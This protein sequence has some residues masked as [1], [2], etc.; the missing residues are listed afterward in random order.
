[1]KRVAI[2]LLSLLALASATPPATT[3]VQWRKYDSALQESAKKK[4]LVLF[5]LHA[6][7]CPP[8]KVMEKTTWSDKSVVQMVEAS[9]IPV[10]LDIDATQPLLHCGEQRLTVN[11]CA[12]S[13]WGVQGLPAIVLLDSQGEYL[14]H[15][16]G[17][18]DAEMMLSFLKIV[19]KETP[20]I[21][22]E[23]QA[24]RDSLEKIER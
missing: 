1:M 7:W 12:S 10:E 23:I 2:V 8:C 9:V 24:Y 17:Y 5:Y 14:F 13:Y 4:R 22:K 19:Q 15:Q 18:F 11:A 21:L 3:A 16:M 6:S 20:Q